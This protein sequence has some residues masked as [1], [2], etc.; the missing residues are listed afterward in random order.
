MKTALLQI[1]FFFTIICS[2]YAQPAFHG[3]IGGCK[4]DLGQDIAF[5]PDGTKYIL[6]NST[7]YGGW[8]DDIVITKMDSNNNHVWSRVF[9]GTE[10]D[11][12]YSIKKY[13]QNILVSGTTRRWINNTMLFWVFVMQIDTAGQII[14]SYRY[15]DGEAQAMIVTDND[16]IVLTGFSYPNLNDRLFALSLDSA[17]NVN[18]AK[19]FYKAPSYNCYGWDIIQSL[20][21]NIIITGVIGV[22]GTTYG[23]RP[24]IIKLDTNGN[25]IWK[26]YYLIHNNLNFYAEVDH[27]ITLL[28]LPSDS[29]L[30]IN[31]TFFDTSSFYASYLLK[32]NSLNGQVIWNKTYDYNYFLETNGVVMLNNQLYMYGFKLNPAT[33][34][35]IAV[36]STD[37]NGNISWTK[38][39]GTANEDDITKLISYN[40]KL[41]ATGYTSNYY[42]PYNVITYDDSYFFEIDT[43]GSALPLLDS[44]VNFNTGLIDSIIPYSNFF[45]VADTVS[46]IPVSFSDSLIY[47]M[48]DTSGCYVI[49]INDYYLENKISIS[50]NPFTNSVNISI[51]GHSSSDVTLSIHNVLGKAV[52]VKQLQIKNPKFQTH[53]DV[54]FLSTG[55]YLLEVIIDGERTVKKMVKE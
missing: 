37:L 38:F 13:K 43:S 19:E 15:N 11:M 41:N 26:N 10:Y 48:L 53:I 40:N 36:M 52:F 50:P 42:S 31:G 55:I 23:R 34:R 28:Q 46:K 4:D 35:D 18:W 16:N 6:T 49:G 2:L 17:G 47:G 51:S 33:T 54:G 7:S 21:G 39:Y 25:I 22:P 44:S 14:W 3:V 20:D 32:V 1:M 30:I 12:G 5:F 9:N 45:A 27:K 29:N 24:V 8:I